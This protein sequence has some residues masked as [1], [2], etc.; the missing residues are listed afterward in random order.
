MLEAFSTLGYAIMNVTKLIAMIAGAAFVGGAYTQV[1]Q[2]PNSKSAVEVFNIVS[3]APTSD[4]ALE[5]S[6]SNGSHDKIP[7]EK[8]GSYEDKEPIN[9]AEVFSE[10]QISDDKQLVGWMPQYMVCAQSWPCTP[11]L[12]LY[13]RGDKLRFV[14]PPSGIVWHWAFFL[15]GKQ[16]VIHYGFPHGDADGEYGL[17]DVSS[18]REIKTYSPD[19]DQGPAPDWTAQ[20]Q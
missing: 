14:I 5:I 17:F 12:V 7:N 4:G 10:I 2:T 19:T 11:E 3:A 13:H 1:P 8:R 15:G 16:I 6:F 9:Q 20:V 18:L